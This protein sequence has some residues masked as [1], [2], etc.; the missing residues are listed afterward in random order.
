MK[1]ALFSNLSRLVPLS[2]MTLISV[3][4]IGLTGCGGGGSSDGST[5]SSPSASVSA[6]QITGFGSIIVN[7]VRFHT[8]GATLEIEDGTEFE[9]TNTNN[10]DHLSRGMEVEIEGSIDDNGNGTATRVFVD[11]TL[12]GPVANLNQTGEVYTFTVLGQM[13]IAAPGMT[14]VDDTVLNSSLGNLANGMVIE[15]H[16]LPD[17]NGKVQASYI[18]WK[19]NSA[20]G[21]PA[22]AF[23]LTG[24][25]V[26]LS[27]PTFMIGS[28][29]V[30]YSNV[31]PRD[32]LLVEGSLV[33][34][35]GN[36]NAAETFVATG[37]EVKSGFDD[38]PEFEVEGLIV[39][40]DTSA[41]TFKVRGQL[42][43]YAAAQFLGGDETELI[44]GVK[45]EAEGPISG[46]VL[47]AEK[48]KFKSGFRY[49]G[50]GNRVGNE[51]TIDNPDGPNLTIIIDNALTRDETTG[52]EGPGEFKV[53]AR[54]LAGAN[55]LATRAEDDAGDPDRQIF[56]APVVR[57][58][59]PLVEILDLDG[60]N[61]VIVVDTS[62][63]SDAPGDSDFEIEDAEVTRAS[64]FASLKVG[65]IVKARYRDNEWD[66]IELELAD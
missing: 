7:G 52:G 26:S 58:A 62:T 30:D 5:P 12:D 57:I 11:S 50:P 1:A 59:A 47:L 14:V 61:G 66:Q 43:N 23:E 22:D 34:V 42:V 29:L 2:L 35:K 56:Q 24:K 48:V 37:V 64:F 10:E 65:D 38:H 31:T 17:G 18:E 19:A 45:V 20:T 28:Q 6:G 60:A 51:L 36:L 40:L 63:M 41:K 44:N 16:G 3:M 54:Q 9:L 55:L 8:G 46:G 39:D 33:E 15:V 13:V 32:G 27:A 25:A 4:I 49:E 53:Q 21:L